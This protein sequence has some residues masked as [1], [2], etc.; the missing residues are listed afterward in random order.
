[1]RQFQAPLLVNNT[2]TAASPGTGDSGD[3]GWIGIA[4]MMALGSLVVEGAGASDTVQV[5]V[6][7]SPFQPVSGDTG[8]ALGSAIAA[9]GATTLAAVY[10]WIRVQ[11][12]SA[13]GS[14][15]VVSV[16]LAGVSFE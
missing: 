12:A 8:V 14:P 4:S 7:N 11:R 1:M 5:Y 10:K 9:A 13:A 3:S 16:Y 6:S 2:H 15:A